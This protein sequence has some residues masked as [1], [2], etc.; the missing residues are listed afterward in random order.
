MEGLPLGENKIKLE[1]LDKDDAVVPS[2]ING[3]E[4]T[5]TLKVEPL[6]N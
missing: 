5:I 3:T 2:P 4:R 1:L 6:K